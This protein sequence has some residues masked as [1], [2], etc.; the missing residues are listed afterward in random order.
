MRFHSACD[1]V[2]T[3]RRLLESSATPRFPMAGSLQSGT[4][5]PGAPLD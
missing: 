1:D 4:P 5:N 3:T 2:G